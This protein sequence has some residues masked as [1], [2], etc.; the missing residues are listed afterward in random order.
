VDSNTELNENTSIKA[1]LE[2]L[3]RVEDEKISIFKL[4]ETLGTSAGL[5]IAIILCSPSALP[6]PAV[7]G[8]TQ[9][10]AFIVITIMAQLLVGKKIIWLPRF[11]GNR[12]VSSGLLKRVANYLL[13][14]DKKINPIVNKIINFISQKLLFKIIRPVNFDIKF[15]VKSRLLFL[16]SIPII[17]FIY[18]FTIILAVFVAM[19]IPFSNTVPSIGVV[20][21]CFG[22]LERDGLII[23][24]GII[25]GLAGLGIL[26][27]LYIYGASQ[28]M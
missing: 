13:N 22:I 1:G 9:L 23:F 4:V 16:T 18:L 17:T 8:I 26:Y 14:I 24:L 7:P 2:S 15:F 5:I 19:P 10:F 27:S 21:I 25:A 6:I 28:V 20:L 12:K 11:L 3:L